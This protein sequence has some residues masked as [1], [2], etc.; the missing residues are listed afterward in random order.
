MYLWIKREWGSVKGINVGFSSYPKFAENYNMTLD[1]ALSFVK[2]KDILTLVK[3]VSKTSFRTIVI[4]VKT[5]NIEGIKNNSEYYKNNQGFI[6]W[7]Q[8]MCGGCGW[9]ITKISN[10]G[11][12]LAKLILRAFL[13]NGSPGWS[14]INDGRWKIWLNVESDRI[15]R[16]EG[17]I[18]CKLTQ[19]NSC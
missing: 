12:I 17:E 15:S 7:E 4:G 8:V 10:V 3:M 11:R 16:G 13:L 1:L 18:L 6:A 2:E 14:D 5:I 9:K 19:Q